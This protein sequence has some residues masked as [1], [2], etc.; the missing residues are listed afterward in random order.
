MNI[1]SV[2]ELFKVDSLDLGEGNLPPGSV[3]SLASVIGLAMIA[4]QLSARNVKDDTP[5]PDTLFPAVDQISNR[6]LLVR[7]RK[8]K[9]KKKRIP[10]YETGKDFPHHT[11]DKKRFVYQNDIHDILP[12]SVHDVPAIDDYDEIDFYEDK[13][14]EYIDQ[15][16]M[17]AIKLNFETNRKISEENSDK[18]KD[19]KFNFKPIDYDNYEYEEVGILN[20]RKP[21][22]KPVSSF[23]KR[24]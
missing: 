16:D 7:R 19:V 13:N 18:I 11:G 4:Q 10:Y 24:L 23:N 1:S 6:R 17:P 20:F 8:K 22:P 5:T 14:Y 9:K 12:Q 15:E 21:P 2:T 3:F